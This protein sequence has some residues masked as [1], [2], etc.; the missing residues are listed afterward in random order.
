[1][2]DDHFSSGLVFPITDRHKRHIEN[3]KGIEQYD[4]ELQDLE[5]RGRDRRQASM[6]GNNRVPVPLPISSVMISYPEFYRRNKHVLDIF[7]MN[8]DILELYEK[9]FPTLSSTSISSHILNGQIPDQIIISELLHN[10]LETGDYPWA[11]F[12]LYRN[13]PDYLV[14]SELIRNHFDLSNKVI[15]RN[16][17]QAQEAMSGLNHDDAMKLK[18]SGTKFVDIE[19]SYT[20][21]KFLADHGFNDKED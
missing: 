14:K 2:I 19:D 9:G 10:L 21:F 17:R 18:L 7:D 20:L 1:M 5:R 4:K 3:I 6:Y 11:F 15:T 13:I 12:C 8:M 16:Y